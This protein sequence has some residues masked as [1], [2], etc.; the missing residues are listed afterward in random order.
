M[1]TLAQHVKTR[2]LTCRHYSR[3]EHIVGKNGCAKGRDLKRLFRKKYGDDATGFMRVLPCDGSAR[4]FCDCPDKDTKTQ[5]E[6]DQENAE[7]KEYLKK[8]DPFIESVGRL[9]KRMIKQR[10][11]TAVATCPNCKAKKSLK[12]SVNIGGNNHCHAR[13]DKC[14][15]GIME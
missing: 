3:R 6:I 10:M 5:A 1:N 14:D 15:M 12:L 8:V 11:A 2:R 13:C 4:P 9:K 7:F